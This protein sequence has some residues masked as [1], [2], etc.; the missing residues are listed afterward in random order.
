MNFLAFFLFLFICLL[1]YSNARTSE[2]LKVRIDDGR[3]VGRWMTSLSGRDIR[4]FMGIPYAAPPIGDLRF[5]V[6]QKV[7]PWGKLNLLAHNEPPMCTQTNIFGDLTARI[8]T[9]QEDC[10]YLNVYTPEISDDKKAKKW[11]V[12]VWLHGGG[13]VVGHSGYTQYGPEYLLEHDIVLVT[14]NYRLGPLGFLSTEDEHASGNFGFKDQLAMLEWVQMNIEKFGGD[15]N[16]VTIFGESAGGAAVNYHMFSSMS[17]G[18]FH[19]AISQSGTLLTPWAGPSAKGQAKMN[20]IRLA[21]KMN[22]SI[23]GTT[24]KEIVTCLRGVPAE[25]IT[26]AIYDFFEWDND[27]IITFQPV[28]EESE[29]EE[30]PFIMD[31]RYKKFSLDIPWM[32]GITSEEGLFKSASIFNSQEKTNDLIKNWEKILPATLFY[33]HL[34][35]DEILELNVKIYDFYFKEEFLGNSKG[36]LTNMWTDGLLGGMF[37][38]L[39]YRLRNNNRDNTFVYL[40]T[41]KGAA[42]YSELF[43]GGR[44]KFYGTCHAD[45]LIYLFPMQKYNLALANSK[46]TEEDKK[47]IQIMTKMWVNFASTGTPTPEWTKDSEFPF[48]TPA[49]KFPLD[50]MQIGNENGLSKK[51]LQMKKNLYP[52]R[53][54]FWTELREKFALH[55]WKLETTEKDEL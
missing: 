31:L 9:G 11:P 40:F 55:N 1:N 26:L 39:A 20:A 49:S 8:V 12:L 14:G 38:N 32:V 28:V 19:R 6:P 3:I 21:D 46:P 7:K 35:E 25:N 5:K 34:H 33:E 24:M 42:S 15:P 16:S 36:N 27:P 41:H 52:E 4:A 47:L 29:L 17:R 13:W 45:D 43:K 50:Y 51:L 37:D 44:E 30:E 23:S 54:R 53:V 18:L 2:S 48:W 22:C 10:L